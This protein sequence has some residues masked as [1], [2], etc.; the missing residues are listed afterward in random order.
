MLEAKQL[1]NSSQQRLIKRLGKQIL[2]SGIAGTALCLGISMTLLTQW[3]TK[4]KVAQ[5]E[6]G[7]AKR[8]AASTPLELVPSS[9]VAAPKSVSSAF[10]PLRQ[11]PRQRLAEGV[12]LSP[13]LYPGQRAMI[14]PAFNQG[15]PHRQAPVAMFN[16]GH[17]VQ[18]PVPLVWS[19]QPVR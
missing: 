17:S 12:V 9:I 8:L 5:E 19:N 14:F 6:R 11:A 15:Y 4:V 2:F 16:S 13:F 18:S 10:E 1:K 3:F 7:R